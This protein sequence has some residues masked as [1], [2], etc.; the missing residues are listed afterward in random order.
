[1]ALSKEQQ[2]IYDQALQE[3]LDKGGVIQ[4]IERGVKSETAT[5]NFWGAPKKKAKE[6]E[7]TPEIDT[8]E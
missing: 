1:M 7:P 2:A 4:Q 3:F 8:E 6:P 5:T